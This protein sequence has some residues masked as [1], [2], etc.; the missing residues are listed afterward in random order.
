MRVR[1]YVQ[2][3]EEEDEDPEEGTGSEGKKVHV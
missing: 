1:E 2:S 3:G